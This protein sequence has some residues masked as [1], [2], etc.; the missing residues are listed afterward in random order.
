M[1]R[2]IVDKIEVEERMDDFKAEDTRHNPYRERILDE[3]CMQAF[4]SKH[5]TKEGVFLSHGTVIA[6]MFARG[7]QS[8]AAS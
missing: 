8:R 7:T 2:Q 4:G 1:G 5:P 6:R 3:V